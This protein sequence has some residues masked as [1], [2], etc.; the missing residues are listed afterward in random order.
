MKL[1]DRFKKLALMFDI[2]SP[3]RAHFL[4]EAKK[5]EKCQK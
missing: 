5:A 2:G 3:L 4:N 1:S